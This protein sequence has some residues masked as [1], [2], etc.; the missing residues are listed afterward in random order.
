VYECDIAPLLSMTPLS[1]PNNPAEP[2][3]TSPSVAMFV[4]QVTMALYAVTPETAT[5]LMTGNCCE[6]RSPKAPL[7]TSNESDN[8]GGAGEVAEITLAARVAPYPARRTTNS[9]VETHSNA[10]LRCLF[11]IEIASSGPRDL[12]MV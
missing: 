5:L 8:G 12:R 11:E 3:P 9:R 2:H 6:E 4:F 7:A 10:R 1:G